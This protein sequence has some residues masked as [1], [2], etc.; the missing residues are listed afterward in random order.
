[1]YAIRSY[2]AVE[3][4]GL[5]VALAVVELEILDQRQPGS[6]PA[7]IQARGETAPDTGYGPELATGDVFADKVSFNSYN[8]V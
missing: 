4:P 1:M 3:L 7:A 5:P 6:I 8:F 2:Y